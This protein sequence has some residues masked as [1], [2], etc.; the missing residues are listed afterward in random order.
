MILNY[1]WM[2]A[3]LTMNYVL[4][5]NIN[6]IMLLVSNNLHKNMLIHNIQHMLR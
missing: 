2:Q 6:M 5:V 4:T 1:N 3:K